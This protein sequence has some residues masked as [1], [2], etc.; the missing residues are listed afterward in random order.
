MSK[1]LNS[2][3]CKKRCARRSVPVQVDRDRYRRTVE[4][5][6]QVEARRA[7]DR[8]HHNS[9]RAQMLFLLKRR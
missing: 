8:G 2:N 4:T 9:R 1:N 7:A 6:E 5:A 3:I